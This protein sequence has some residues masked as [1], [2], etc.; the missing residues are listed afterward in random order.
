MAALLLAVGTVATTPAPASADL[1]TVNWQ[2]YTWSDKW[3]CTWQSTPYGLGTV[4]M[5]ACV[6]VN[7]TLTQSAVIVTNSS[8]G[9]S[10]NISAINRL[11][12]NTNIVSAV[13]C[14]GSVLSNGYTRAC[15]GPTKSFSCTAVVQGWTWVTL[16]DVT[17]PN[18]PDPYY[19]NDWYGPTRRMCIT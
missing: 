1:P 3:H 9:K 2:P 12:A 4:S 17:S 19:G 14:N 10:I 8:K 5:G 7:G 18:W 15:F 6:I 11:I 13:S 16:T